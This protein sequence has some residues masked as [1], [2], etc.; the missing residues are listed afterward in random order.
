MRSAASTASG[1]SAINWWPAGTVCTRARSIWVS[2]LAVSAE[3]RLETYEN[4]WNNGGILEV[5]LS[6]MDNLSSPAANE[7]LAE[8]FSPGD[9]IL[10]DAARDGFMFSKK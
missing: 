5:A 10:I 4:A 2:A 1:A 7:L 8:T 9:T 6:Y 3:E